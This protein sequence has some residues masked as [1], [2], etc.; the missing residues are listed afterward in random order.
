[1]QLF[2]PCDTK[3]LADKIKFVL[4]NEKEVIRL[5]KEFREKLLRYTWNDAAQ[6]YYKLMDDAIREQTKTVDLAQGER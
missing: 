6:A 3:D 5:Q 1:M 2:D 4:Q